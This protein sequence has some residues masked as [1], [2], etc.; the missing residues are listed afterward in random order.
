M[1][2]GNSNYICACRQCSASKSRTAQASDKGQILK[3]LTK[4]YKNNYWIDTI[5][6]LKIAKASTD[7]KNYIYYIQFIF[8][9]SKTEPRWN[10][11]VYFSGSTNSGYAEGETISVHAITEKVTTGLFSVIP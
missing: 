10:F 9:G 3:C 4:D 2:F 5:E 1:N 11:V 7:F 6:A 8:H